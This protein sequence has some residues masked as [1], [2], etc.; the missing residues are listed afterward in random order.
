MLNISFYFGVGK[1]PIYLIKTVF[2]QHVAPH[3]SISQFHPVHDKITVLLDKI[4]LN[5]P[6]PTL[7]Q[8]LTPH[9]LP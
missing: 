4:C 7:R 2:S 3:E 8:V 9:A 5:N 6:K 1:T